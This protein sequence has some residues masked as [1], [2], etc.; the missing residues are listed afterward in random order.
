MAGEFV[1][2]RLFACVQQPREGSL[3]TLIRGRRKAWT[4]EELSEILNLSQ[5]HILKMAKEQRIPSYRLGGSVRFD[6]ASTADWLG[7]RFVG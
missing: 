4:A 1:I 3:I 2:P 6:P 7:A 5:K